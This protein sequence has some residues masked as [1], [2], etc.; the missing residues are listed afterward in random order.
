MDMAT[1][2][3][4]MNW[5]LVW[6]LWSWEIYKQIPTQLKFVIPRSHVVDE[7]QSNFPF[8]DPHMINERVF[9]KAKRKCFHVALYK[10]YFEKVKY[11]NYSSN[12]LLILKP[13]IFLQRMSKPLLEQLSQF[14]M[15][16]FHE[17]P[18]LERPEQNEE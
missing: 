3:R 8:L 18:S 6:T 1:S 9:N 13:D 11:G 16:P 5:L 17:Q 7:R 12:H 14:P 15:W 2:A 10:K 4:R